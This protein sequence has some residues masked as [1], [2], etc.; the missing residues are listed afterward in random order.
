MQKLNY[1]D[2]FCINL[3][4]KS[5]SQQKDGLYVW[6]TDHHLL[7]PILPDSYQVFLPQNSL[8]GVGTKVS[9]LFFYPSYSMM[10]VLLSRE[11]RIEALL[12]ASILSH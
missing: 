8:I 12:I 2:G 11:S 10:L 6:C 9:P 4:G 1:L 5:L 3:F 7:A